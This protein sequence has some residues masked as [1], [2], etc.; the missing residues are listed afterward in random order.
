MAVVSKQIQRQFRELRDTIDSISSESS[1]MLPWSEKS[2]RVERSRVDPEYFFKTYLGKVYFKCDPAPWHRELPVL[3]STSNFNLPLIIVAPRGGAKTTFLFGETLRLIVTG[4][5]R[6]MI[7]VEVSEKV[8]IK[9]I[10]KVRHEIE[11]NRQLC[12]D[13]GNLRSSPWKAEELY[14]SNGSMLWGR[15]RQQPVRGVTYLEWRPT[16]IIYN[17][18]ETQQQVLNQDKTDEIYNALM[19]EALPAL[20]PPGPSGGG[21]LAVVGTLLGERSMLAQLLDTPMTRSVKYR[22]L[23]GNEEA[24]EL[25]L[26]KVSHDTRDIDQ[27]IR[28][29]SSGKSSDLVKDESLVTKASQYFMERPDY[30][31]LMNQ[32]RSFWPA[33]FTVQALLLQ[34]VIIGVPAFRQEYLHD[35]SNS[36]VTVPFPRV[37]FTRPSMYYQVQD[38]PIAPGRLAR[39]TYLD[40]SYKNTPASD[41]IA[42]VTG[43]YDIETGDGYIIDVTAS[44]M[45]L[46]DMIQLAF[47]LAKKYLLGSVIVDGREFPTSCFLNTVFGYEDNAAQSWLESMFAAKSERDRIYLPKL[48]GMTH[49]SNK[50][51]RISQHLSYYMEHSMIKF[52]EKND[53][54]LK[55]INELCSLGNKKMHD[56]RADALEGWWSLVEKLKVDIIMAGKNMGITMGNI[57]RGLLSFRESLYLHEQPIRARYIPYG[58]QQ[59]GVWNQRDK[60]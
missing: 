27:Y 35:P 28:Q 43:F 13:F 40:P 9:E 52:I 20:N 26:E 30:I 24:I 12:E 29:F 18:V 2:Y 14:F 42:F 60:V 5:Q 49:S 48:T 46:D 4:Q 22:A 50:Y 37:W 39:A 38:I 23:E 7:R 25:L 33:R 55:L 3:L 47:D 57:G 34:A 51:L 36:N 11:T 8:A 32:V 1:K 16:G 56:D 54:Q 19:Y 44:Q 31:A 17:D 41:N 45:S 21:F 6:F 15:G 10:F 58:Q 59:Y 53:Q